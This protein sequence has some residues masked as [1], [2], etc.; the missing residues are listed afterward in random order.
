MGTLK[1]KQF[2]DFEIEQ[3]IFLPLYQYI[4]NHVAEK[5]HKLTYSV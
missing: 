3:Y 5:Q 4:L 2:M 1:Y